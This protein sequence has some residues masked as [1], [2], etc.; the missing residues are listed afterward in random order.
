MILNDLFL[1][2]ILT[3]A[4]TPTNAHHLIPADWLSSMN[5]WPRILL[6]QGS[7][8]LLGSKALQARQGLSAS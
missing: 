8:P 5:H 2:N 3:G 4:K 7:Q 6:N 1:P